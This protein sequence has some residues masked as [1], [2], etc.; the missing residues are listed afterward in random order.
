[1]N[2]VRD[3]AFDDELLLAC[4]MEIPDASDHRW[5]RYGNDNEL[6]LEGPASM[7]GPATLEYFTQLALLAPTLSEYFGIDGLQMET[8]GGGYHLIP[9]GG[10]L[11]IHTDFSRSPDEAVPTPQRPHLP[12]RGLGRGR[13]RRT[14][15]M[16]RHALCRIDQARVR[17]DGRLCYLVNLV[18]WSPE[19][20]QAL[21]GVTRRL[22]LHR[23]PASRFQGAVDGLASDRRG[24]CMTH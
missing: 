21:A 7:W 6:K 1:M 9:P 17:N 20:N 14:R 15:T 22:L 18:A 23:R 2:L 11:G 8:I 13:R 10:Y 5:R 24:T 19:T 4:R 12:Q 16:G 3:D